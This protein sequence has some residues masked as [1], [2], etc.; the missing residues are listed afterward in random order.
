MRTILITVAMATLL[1]GDINI[2]P[3]QMSKLGITTTAPKPATTDAI[4]PLVGSVDFDEAHSKS[5]ILDHEA[6]IASLN[7]RA[8]DS[9]KK[10]E[11]LATISSAK[12]VSDSF[13]LKSLQEQYKLAAAHAKKDE[14]LFSDG[15]ISQREMQISQLNAQMLSSKISTLKSQLAL[16]GINSKMALVASQSGIVSLAP[17]NAGE[18]IMPFTPY[19]RISSSNSMLVHINIP[20]ALLTSIRKGDSITLEDGKKIGSIISI[21]QGISQNTN[22]AIATAKAT[23]TTLLAGSTATFFIASTHAKKAYLLPSSSVVRQGGKNICFIRSAS[24]FRVQEVLLISQSQ[25]GAVVRGVAPSDAVAST[26]IIALKGALNGL[27]F[28]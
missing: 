20:P 6:S 9:V 21:S 10:G 11:V 4:G 12:L 25:N 16:S 5:F 28:E 22:S 17:K 27:G 23:T 1:L 24:G 8:G 19:F 14:A 18:K 7:K 13:E 15:V 2:S 3:A 26:G